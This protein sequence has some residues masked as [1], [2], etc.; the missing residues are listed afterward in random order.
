MTDDADENSGYFLDLCQCI[1]FVVLHWS[2]I[3]QQLDNWV[4]VCFI[5]CGGKQFQQKGGVPR[6]LTSKTDFLKRCFNRLPVLAPSGMR[7]SRW[8]RGSRLHRIEGMTSYTARLP[9]SDRTRRVA[10]SG[11]AASA[12][13]AISIHSGNSISHRTSSR[14]SGRFSP[15]S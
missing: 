3:E 12:I 1:G 6:S 7:A 15:I 14:R 13:K 10:L 2:L 5:N 8:S 4:N 11:F 9:N